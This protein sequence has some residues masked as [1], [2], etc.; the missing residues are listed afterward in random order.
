M[1]TGAN[2]LRRNKCL[3][4]SVEWVSK[5]GEKSV[6]NALEVHTIAE[7][8]DRAFP[9]PKQDR[10]GSDTAKESKPPQ[11]STATTEQNTDAAPST[12]PPASTEAA[13]TN[14]EPLSSSDAK[15]PADT[16]ETTT[17]DLPITPHRGLY[18]YLHRPRTTTKKPV[19]VPLPPSAPL[20]DVLRERTVLEFPT[21]YTLPESTELLTEKETSSFI[22]EEEYLRT[23]GPEDAADKSAESEQDDA[24]GPPESGPNLQDVDENKVLEVLKQ[25]LFEPAA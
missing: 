10:R 11:E 24:S 17:A 5:A 20:K 15:P 23:V 4:W 18:F 2:G 3:S 1:A 19:L 6:R 14:E 8:Y 25:D 13:A 9:P 12:A 16:A 22:L 7:A 21:V